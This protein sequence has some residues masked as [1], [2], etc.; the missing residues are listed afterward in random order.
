M[1]LAAIVMAVDHWAHI[2]V[3]PTRES[4]GAGNARGV[5]LEEIV[6]RRW[7]VIDYAAKQYEKHEQEGAG[8]EEEGEPCE[9]KP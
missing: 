4:W 9:E 1:D 6:H 7:L 5:C 3:C 2:P 8:G